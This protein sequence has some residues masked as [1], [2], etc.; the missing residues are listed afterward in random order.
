MGVDL[1]EKSFFY[2]ADVMSGTPAIILVCE[3]TSSAPVCQAR[4]TDVWDPEGLGR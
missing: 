4:R 3:G 1:T 2:R